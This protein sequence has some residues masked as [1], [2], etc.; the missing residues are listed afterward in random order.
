M[1]QAARAGIPL[2]W[3]LFSPSWICC[4]RSRLL[5]C[6]FCDPLVLHLIPSLAI[7]THATAVQLCSLAIC[8]GCDL[9][10]NKLYHG[11]STTLVTQ[12]AQLANAQLHGM[13][14]RDGRTRGRNTSL[15]SSVR[16]AAPAADDDFDAERLVCQGLMLNAALPSALGLGIAVNCSESGVH[17]S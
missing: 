10:S 8:S 12:A 14:L 7:I 15:Y 4:L 11:E 5:G 17:T 13:A 3:M 2:I 16:L 9:Q 1:L 6:R